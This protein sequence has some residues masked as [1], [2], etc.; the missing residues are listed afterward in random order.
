MSQLSH[1]EVTAQSRL[2]HSSSRRG[3]SSIMAITAQS[4]LGHSSIT[5]HVTAQSRLAVTILVTVSSPW[6]HCELTVSS[7]WAHRKQSRWPFFFL[8]MGRYQEQGQPTISVGCN[9]LSLPLISLILTQ[10][11]CLI[12]LHCSGLYLSMYSYPYCSEL[13]QWSTL[14]DT[15][16]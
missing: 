13:L 3:H 5:A 4:R 9:Y 10:P 8:L 15:G 16:I 6:A 1:G 7:P 11:F 12:K 14:K 2:G